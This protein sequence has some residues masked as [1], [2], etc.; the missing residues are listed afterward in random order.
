MFSNTYFSQYNASRG[1]EVILRR[2]EMERLGSYN[3][4]LSSRPKWDGLW[5]AGFC[6]ELWEVHKVT[7]MCSHR[8][9]IIPYMNTRSISKR[10]QGWFDLSQSWM[11]PWYAGSE[12]IPITECQPYIWPH[13]GTLAWAT[14]CNL[15]RTW[16][17]KLFKSLCCQMR[18]L[19]WEAVCLKVM[20][21]LIPKPL[22]LTLG[23]LSVRDALLAFSEIGYFFLG[24]QVILPE[25]IPSLKLW[26]SLEACSCNRFKMVTAAL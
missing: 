17:M 23:W 14:S 12:G 7:E 8:R 24:N 4:S 10:L 2:T 26:S 5:G 16:L 25:R 6:L 15:E 9:Q 3:S 11:T 20:P 1:S 19:G 18:Q 21:C 22:A 13:P